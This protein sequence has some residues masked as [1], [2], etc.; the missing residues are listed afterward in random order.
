MLQ[1]LSSHLLNLTEGKDLKK[2]VTD[3]AHQ[4]DK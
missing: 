1:K 2:I 4:I 3:I